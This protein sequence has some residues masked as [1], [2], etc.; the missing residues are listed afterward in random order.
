VSSGFLE[1]RANR[2]VFA[3]SLDKSNKVLFIIL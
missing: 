1:S 3:F 2:A